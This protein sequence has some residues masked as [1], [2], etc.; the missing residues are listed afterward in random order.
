MLSACLERFQDADAV[1]MAAAVADFKPKKKSDN[2]IK[3]KQG[4][5]AISLI[6][7]PDILARLGE[8]KSN[9]LLIGFALESQNAIVNAEQKLNNKNLDA[10][11]VNSLE[12]SGAGFGYDT[13]KISFLQRGKDAVHYPL[14]SKDGVAEDILFHLKSMLNES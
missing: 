14:K 7:T 12:D 2:K 8:L 4:I 6:P 3:K 5:G 11:I 10:I 1:V 9:Q 13:N